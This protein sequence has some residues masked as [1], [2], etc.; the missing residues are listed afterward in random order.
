[1]E[2]AIKSIVRRHYISD[3]NQTQEAIAARDEKYVATL[4]KRLAKI[5]NWLDDNDDKPG[6]SGPRKSNIT[7]NGSAKMKTA[8]GVIQGYDGV[9]AVDSKHQ[10]IVHAAAFGQGHE[11]DLLEPMIA[12][13]RE[14][15]HIIGKEENIF[16]ATKLTADSGFHSGKNMEM[17][18]EQ[19]IDAYVAD[20]QFRKRDPRFADVDRY[21]ERSR[22]ERAQRS[23]HNRLFT[24]EDFAF[25]NDLSYCL[26]P[27]GKR[28]YRNGGNVV[29]RGLR[30]VRFKG[31]KS[32]CLPC[33]FRIQCLR[34]P[35]RTEIRQV[36]YFQGRTEKSQGH[37]HRK[38]EAQD[39]FHG[40]P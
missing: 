30:S 22:K 31:P 39:R 18:S 38:D 21:K 24:T 17:L 16:A 8:K 37:L 29:T 5:R 2:K 35:E 1:M 36:A 13:T 27:A 15:F 6:K 32:A 14:N 33:N 3:R 28:L 20:T 9:T 19:E 7:D 25:A 12:G 40:W 23:G 4:R 26:C 11:H 10:I 34:H